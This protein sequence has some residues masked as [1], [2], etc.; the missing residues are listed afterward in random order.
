MAH[1]D[2]HALRRRPTLLVVDD[3]RDTLHFLKRLIEHEAGWRVEMADSVQAGRSLL[4]NRP[5]AALIDYELPD[6]TGVELSLELRGMS[7]LAPII[8]MTGSASPF[9]NE[10]VERNGFE[11]LRKP[12]LASDVIRSILPALVRATK[13]A[14]TFEIFFSYSHR[15]E[16]LRDEL[17]KHLSMLKRN[18]LIDAWH[19][20]KIDAGTEFEESIIVQMERAKIIMLLVSPDFIASDFCYGREMERALRRHEEEDARVIPVILRPVDW[21]DAPFAK[22]LALPKDG[23]PVT[24]WPSRDAAFLDIAR[25]VKR[26]VEALRAS[27]T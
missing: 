27:G 20:R 4:A 1:L 25:G 21:S 12:F 7:P 19:D 8:V 22:L 11:L 13:P 15:D 10:D 3:N 2:H 17:E 24:T 18:Q 26:I 23:K 6:G 5:D 9:V 14:S 16:R